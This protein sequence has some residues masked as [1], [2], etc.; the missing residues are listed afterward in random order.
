MRAMTSIVFATRI[1]CGGS[2]FRTCTKHV[3]TYDDFHVKQCNKINKFKKENRLK[4]KRNGKVM[5]RMERNGDK[6]DLLVSYGK[7]PLINISNC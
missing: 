4:T 7:V 6:T 1:G 5:L 2:F 3:L